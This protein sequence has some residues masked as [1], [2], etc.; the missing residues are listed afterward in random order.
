MK[1]GQ[2]VDLVLGEAKFPDV[3]IKEIKSEGGSW[4]VDSDGVFP[5]SMSVLVEFVTPP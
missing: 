2:K 5:S 4:K 3:T 1:A